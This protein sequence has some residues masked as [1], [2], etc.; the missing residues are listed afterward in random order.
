MAISKERKD[1]LVGKY[2]EWVKKSQALIVTEY[3]GL[4]MKQVDDIRG[5]IRE[6]GG[7]FHIVKNTLGEVALTSAGIPVNQKLLTGSTAIAFAFK[8]APQLAKVISD[9]ARTSEFV[10]IKGGYLNERAISAEDV[11]NLAEMPPLPV[12]RAQLLGMLNAPASKLVRTLAEPGRA[13]A[14]VVRAYS[15]KDNAPEAAEAAA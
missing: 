7:E 4:S 9:Y 1:E 11:K 2:A 3:A 10:K 8:D 15:E 12:M 5:K 14:S 13:L 6:A